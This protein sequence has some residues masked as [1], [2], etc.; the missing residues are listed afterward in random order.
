[1]KRSRIVWIIVCAAVAL[2]AIVFTACAKVGYTDNRP[3]PDTT[4]NEVLFIERNR[5]SFALGMEIDEL[6]VI[7]RCVCTFKD[8]DGSEFKVTAKALK[9]GE[10]EY[11]SFD[12]DTVGSNKQI[13][14]SRGGAVNYIYYDVNDYT[15]NLYLDDDYTELYQTVK[16]SAQ[17]TENLGLAVWVNLIQCNFSTDEVMRE[18]DADRAMRFDGWYDSSENRA[19]GLYTLA[20]PVFG[21]ERVMDFHA[22]YLS[23]S[24]FA[25]LK[26]SYD[27]SGR[28]VFSGYVG[29]SD[30]V[31]VPEGV[32]Y[33]DLAAMFADGCT[34]K[35]INIPSTANIDVPF[36]SGYNSGELETITV[37]SGNTIYSSYNGALYSKDYTTL[38]FMPSGNKNTEFHSELAV[39]GSYSCSYWRVTDLTIPESVVVLQH[40]C[41]AHSQISEV[42]GL[43]NVK[44]IKTGAFFDSKM[45]SFTDGKT[46]QYIM[47]DGGDS[48]K[49]ILSMILDE[50]ITEYTVIRGTVGIAGDV[51]G[52]CESLTTVNL[53]NELRSIGSSA[54]AGCGSLE[55]ITLPSTLEKMGSSVFYGCSALKTVVG[56][57]DV[58]YVDDDGNEYEHMLPSG[59]FRDCANLESVT[60]PDGIVNIGSNAFR[61]CKALSSVTLPDT[62]VTIG[63][64]G[65]YGCGMTEIK[66]SKSLRRLGAYV[67]AS[68]ALTGIDLSVCEQLTS[69]SENCF[70]SSRLTEI[71]IPD[72]ITTIPMNCFYTCS[73]LKKVVLGK[74][75]V[76]ENQAFAGCTA[77]S[78]IDLDGVESIGYRTF[79]QCNR[80]VNFVLPDSVKYVGGQAFMSCG[81]LTSI[82][83]GK[84]VQTFGEYVF[85]NDGVSFMGN[86]TQRPALYNCRK[87][88]KILV[89]DGN[90][91]FKSIDG[92]LYG[93]SICGIDY[94]EGSVLYSVP[95]ARENTEFVSAN[96][97]RIVAPYALHY[98]VKLTTATFNEGLENIGLGAFYASSN[99]VAV[100]LPSTVT[101]IGAS[102]LLS[103]SKVNE[104]TIDQANKTYSSDGDLVYLGDTLV[105]YLGLNKKINIKDGI[106]KIDFAVF[107]NNTSITEIVIPDSVT[108]IGEKAFSG[109]SAIKSL[110]IGSG[111]RHLDSTAFALL[112][113]LE[114]I[115]VSADNPYFIAENNILYTKDGKSLILAAAHNGMTELNIKAGVT[116]ICDYAFCYHTT[117]KNVVMP[118]TVR[119]VG[120]YAFYEC[121]GIEKLYCSEALESIGAY[122]FA[123][124]S[125][126]PLNVDSTNRFCDSLKVVMFYGNL[127]SIGDFAFNGQ[128]GI[129]YTF[130]KMTIS[131]LTTL[132]A[133]LGKNSVFITLGCKNHDGDG[134]YNN[135]GFGI[136]RALYSAVP[137]TIDYNGYE[138]FYLENGMPTIYQQIP[139]REPDKSGDLKL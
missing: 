8:S 10:V 84:N 72:R 119:L 17:L 137:P 73:L 19:T 121:R 132:L 20:P 112:Q 122:A 102:I 24:D 109:C 52:R 35:S 99:L 101:N 25:D 12:L 26:L 78:D 36:L 139:A 128:F 1:M 21:N 34:F 41:F 67:F 82:T 61:N 91:Y 51:F 39:I 43:E 95:P 89:S 32:T 77:L 125:G 40:Y 136:I 134:Y 37:N 96:S 116:E 56:L 130:Y 64:Y 38:H 33:I 14:I 3:V 98:Q 103:C 13:R 117:L 27:S 87:L 46:A 54:F 92:V 11:E 74:V 29:S 90:L 58:T 45:K 65:F 28:R 44:T 126:S 9:S 49:Y 59:I 114:T 133:G 105:M 66:L 22:H 93:R 63:S 88:Q 6:D 71:T 127:R 68:T 60:I 81:G 115:T 106:T 50:S 80:F 69:L 85:E 118:N 86:Q 2:C 31:Q 62:V 120:D 97:T 7:E 135:G 5:L 129:E 94:G 15:A 18:Y 23:E 30:S 100:H 131:E 47:L 113:S 123:F 107:M 48:G 108:T 57:P 70:R 75:T 83:L 42:R 55:S 4:K 76:I 16:A 79:Q 110:H 138:W 104:F 53:G 111:L 124:D